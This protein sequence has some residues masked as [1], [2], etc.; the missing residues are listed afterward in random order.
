MMQFGYFRSDWRDHPELDANRIA[1]LAVLSTYAS[2][3]GSCWPSQSTLATKLKRSRAWVNGVLADLCDLGIL[4]K[5]RRRY[6]HGGEKSCLY[7]L[8]GHDELFSADT[9]LTPSAAEADTNTTKDQQ[10][11]DTLSVRNPPEVVEQE[12]PRDWRPTGQDT[13]YVNQKL[14]KLLSIPGLVWRST[15]L[16]IYTC[17]SNGRRFPPDRISDAWRAWMLRERGPQSARP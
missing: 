7:R 12:V 2:P 11:K 13:D 4:T 3:D 6:L 14:P 10:D 8:T 15:E 16:F 9:P 17:R 5:L 1:V